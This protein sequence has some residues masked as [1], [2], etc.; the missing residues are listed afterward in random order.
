MSFYTE[1]ITKQVLNQDTGE[2]E[3]EVYTRDVRKKSGIKQGWTMTYID[4]DEM[5]ATVVKSNLDMKL[6][7]HLKLMIKRDFTL[8]INVPKE[9][10]KIDVGKDKIYKMLKR[11]VD[12]EFLEKTDTGYKSNPFMFLPYK[13]TDAEGEQ[14][15][16]KLK[17]EISSEI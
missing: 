2:V 6:V 1:S 15:K 5:L 7:M 4:Y 14:R 9:A 10:K 11:L 3:N 8:T 17:K 16:W 12:A 13:P